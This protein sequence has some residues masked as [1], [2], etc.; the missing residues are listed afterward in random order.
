MT[1]TSLK[2][3]FWKSRRFITCATIVVV[4]CVSVGFMAGIWIT[5][6]DAKITLRKHDQAN[7]DASNARRAVM[8]QCLDNN[9]IMSKQLADLGI[10]AS[11]A[12]NEATNAINTLSSDESTK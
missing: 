2:K 12:A 5:A 10:K 8:Q 1:M 4:C 7:L 9:A 11:N 3:S 6:Y